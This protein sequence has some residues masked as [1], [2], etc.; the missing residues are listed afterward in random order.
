MPSPGARALT[1]VAAA[2]QRDPRPARTGMPRCS[3]RDEAPAPSAAGQDLRTLT[4]PSSTGFRRPIGS[5]GPGDTG[6]IQTA[7]ARRPG[8]IEREIV[9]AARARRAHEDLAH[10]PVRVEQAGQ[11]VRGA[12]EALREDRLGVGSEEARPE[13]VGAFHGD[14]LGRVGRTPLGV[15]R[16]VAQVVEDHHGVGGE[17]DVRPDVVLAPVLHVVVAV[18]GRRVQPEAIL[19]ERREGAVR[20]GRS[21]AV[22]EVDEDVRALGCGLHLG[23]GGVRAVQLDHPGAV[24]AGLRGVAPAVGD[25]LRGARSGRTDDHDDL[26]AGGRGRRAGVGRQSAERQRAT[27]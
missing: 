16:G 2:A 21:V 5:S 12:V 20:A 15:A 14:R 17:V 13:V 22:P 18:A 24:R 3:V 1:D 9:G 11:E 7:L 23:P 4:T 25:V 27:G 10:R 26:H 19:G 8:G 6:S